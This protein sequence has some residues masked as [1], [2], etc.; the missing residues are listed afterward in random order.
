MNREIDDKINQGL[1]NITTNL[2]NLRGIEHST[3]SMTVKYQ[4][5]Q[6]VIERVYK[7]LIKRK[8][9]LADRHFWDELHD[10]MVYYYNYLNEKNLSKSLPLFRVVLHN[11]AVRWWL[12][13][14][15]RGKISGP[16]VHF[17]THDDMGL[18]DKTNGLLKNGKLDEDGIAKG[19]CGQIYWPITCMLISKGIDQVIWAMPNW[20]YDDDNGFTQ[21]LISKTPSQG[22]VYYRDEDQPKDNFIMEGDVEIVSSNKIEDSSFLF[23]HE[24][25]FDRLKVIDRKS[26][27]KLGRIIDD[28]HFILDIDLDYFVTNGDVCNKAEYQEEFYDL[29]STGRVHDMPGMR[30]PR[31]AYTDDVS[32]E[33]KKAL[34]KEWKMVEKR[35]QTFLSGL[36]E[37]K[38]KGITPC[39]I[40]ISD[41]APSFFGGQPESGVLSNNYTP[42]YFVPAIHFLLY[43][44]FEKL[45]SI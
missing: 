27:T 2:Y 32:E 35:I 17:D 24:F 19:N 39:C 14:K 23:D 18:P 44:G 28:K 13:C 34:R 36:A 29:E 21:H 20:V 7:E 12:K 6:S 30:T 41:S 45:Y 1:Y 25:R 40:D 33:A 15:R 37:L 4:K 10:R 31:E 9:F 8:D 42:K 43:K 26:W 16:L 38:R 11:D 3:K 5:A 22:F